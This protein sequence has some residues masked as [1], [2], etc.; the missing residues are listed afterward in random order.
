MKHPNELDQQINN[1]R[2]L[3][4]SFDQLAS[5]LRAIKNAHILGFNYDGI[6][7]AEGFE[8]T[9]AFGIIANRHQIS[10]V[11]DDTD[12]MLPMMK[13]DDYPL[14]EAFT[15]LNATYCESSAGSEWLIGSSSIKKVILP[16]LQLTTPYRFI[17]SMAALRLLDLAYANFNNSNGSISGVPDLIDIIIGKG[18]TG[19]CN[20]LYL[21]SPTNALM[22]DSTSLLTDEDIAAG[23]TSKLEKLLYNIREH[24]AANLNPEITATITFSAA[25]YAA[26]NAD[27]DTVDSFPASWTIAS[28]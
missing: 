1:L 6:V 28:A 10:I 16:R 15:M 2:T 7:F 25:V 23:F 13:K 20:I 3:Q 14:L 11:N 9:S 24:I 12:E 18:F 26:I 27:Q 22:S 21:W 8:P 17:N 4:Q 19:S 5:D